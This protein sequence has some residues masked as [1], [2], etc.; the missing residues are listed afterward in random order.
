MTPPEITDREMDELADAQPWPAIPANRLRQIQTAVI[1]DLEPVR[2]LASSSV[3][4]LAFGGLFL[5]VFCIGCYMVGQYGWHALSDFQR[6]AVFVPLTAASALLAFSLVRQM[7]PA[8]KQPRTIALWAAGSF[9]FLLLIM[10]VIFRPA[11]ESAFVQQGLGCFK[12][13]MMFAIPAAFLF[14][15]L[16]L[17]GAVLSPAL[18]GATAGG[19]AGLVGL[20]VLEIHC[21]NLNVY[22]IV[23]WH[24]SVTLVC[25]VAGLVI[26]SVT[27]RRWTSN[28]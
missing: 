19:L 3:Y 23:V 20:G 21:P 8:A 12:T 27:F 7:R 2:P 1:A 22:H 9:V 25:V 6:L 11:P 5:A 10:T 28:H 14:A 15:L 26:S 16:L 17:R 4:L 24:V 18:L 13:G